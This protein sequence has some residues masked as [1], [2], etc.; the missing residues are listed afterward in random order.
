[1]LLLTILLITILPIA[2]PLF[3]AWLFA[4]RHRQKL[5]PGWKLAGIALAIGVTTQAVIYA[6]LSG[7]WLLEY[8]G[9]CGGWLGETEPCSFGQ[10]VGETM[11]WVMFALSISSVIGTLA[12]VIFLF[13][14][15]FAARVRTGAPPA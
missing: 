14:K 4:R 10:Y 11:L 7:F 13:L 3:F 6:I 5:K 15:A 9:L 1:M 2:A 8:D 12:S